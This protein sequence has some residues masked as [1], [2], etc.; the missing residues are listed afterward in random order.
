MNQDPGSRSFS[1]TTVEALTVTIAPVLD[2]AVR[3]IL[4]RLQA[5]HMQLPS[6]EYTVRWRERAGPGLVVKETTRS[7][8]NFWLLPPHLLFPLARDTLFFGELRDLLDKLLVAHGGLPGPFEH[9]PGEV[10]ALQLVGEVFEQEGRFNYNSERCEEVSRLLARDLTA[11]TFEAKHL[12]LVKDF[13]AP[14][15]FDLSE[16]IAIRPVTR[17]DAEQCARRTRAFPSISDYNRYPVLGEDW[18]IDATVSG[19]RSTNQAIEWPHEGGK[20][21]V[22]V[23]LTLACSGHSSLYHL[24][25]YSAH[26]FASVGTSWGTLPEGLGAARHGAMNFSAEHVASAQRLF[27]QLTGASQALRSGLTFAMRR[28]LSGADRRN[29]EDR[30]VD[31]VIALERL[32]APDSSSLEVTYRFRMRGAVILPDSYGDAERR[33]ALMTDLYEA[34]SRVVHGDGQQDAGATADQAGEVLRSV[35]LWYLEPSHLFQEPRSLMRTIDQQ[36]VRR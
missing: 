20:D 6:F 9:D 32:L 15:A 5:A 25:S 24:M 29:D 7:E 12:F 18:V 8:P 22:R 36:M 14:S 27:G 13:H 2:K 16:E 35:L 11:S 30:V 4:E 1:G 34:R 23:A 17:D 31:Y 10:V 28:M 33:L 19:P 26:P 3:G 21:A